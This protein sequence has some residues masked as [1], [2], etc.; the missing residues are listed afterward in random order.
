MD[1]DLFGLV[2][3]VGAEVVFTKM[4]VQQL[5]L[6]AEALVSRYSNLDPALREDLTAHREAV[7]LLRGMFEKYAERWAQHGLE[8]KAPDGMAHDFNKVTH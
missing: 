2:K 7:L 5:D 4:S 8:V 6:Q 3:D 1:D